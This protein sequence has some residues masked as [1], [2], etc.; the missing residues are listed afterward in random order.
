MLAEAK[1]SPKSSR[2]VAQRSRHAWAASRHVLWCTANTLH[3]CA[4]QSCEIRPVLVTV[5]NVAVSFLLLLLLPLQPHLQLPAAAAAGSA[6]HLP[7]P[8]L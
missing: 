7:P 6:G 5:H 8:V 2:F 1:H 4:Y 3:S